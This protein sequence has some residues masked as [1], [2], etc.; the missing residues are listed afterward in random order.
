MAISKK[1]TIFAQFSW[2]FV[3]II[4]TW[5]GNIAWIWAQLDQNY[6]LFTKTKSFGFSIFLSSIHTLI[7]VHCRTSK[8]YSTLSN[9]WYFYLFSKAYNSP[10]NLFS[11]LKFFPLFTW[12]QFKPWH[13]S[14][15][16]KITQ[17]KIVLHL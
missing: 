15:S 2:N 11:A 16:R 6:R 13:L 1:S 3:K 12:Y 10:H 17:F 8:P 5:L 9:D 7:T 4:T 14:I